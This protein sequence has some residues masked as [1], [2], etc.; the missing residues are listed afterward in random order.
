MLSNREEDGGA[1]GV[2]VMRVSDV[3]A[4]AAE[5][6]IEINDTGVA[7]HIELRG[8]DGNRI[9]IVTPKFAK[10]PRPA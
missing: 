1:R 7:R 5:F 6:G 3:S 9:R 2:A 10:R 8:A 4:I